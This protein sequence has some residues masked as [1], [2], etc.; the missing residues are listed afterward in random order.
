M[1]LQLA[2]N[3]MILDSTYTKELHGSEIFSDF[4]RFQVENPYQFYVHSYSLPITT[5]WDKNI[6]VQI[7]ITFQQEL[8]VASANTYASDTLK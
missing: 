1:T 3:Q 5:A 4:V 2:S 8:L 7:A 6:T